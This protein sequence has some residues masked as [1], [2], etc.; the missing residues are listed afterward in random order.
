MNV[1]ADGHIISYHSALRVKLFDVS[2]FIL[3]KGLKM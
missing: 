2:A 1:K 3:I